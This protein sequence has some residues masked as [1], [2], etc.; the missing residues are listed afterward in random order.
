[1]TYPSPPWRLTGFGFQTIH[2]LDIDRVSALIPS[3]LD[4]VSVLPGKTLGTVYVAAYGEGSALIYNE[5][6][7]VNA[8]VRHGSKIGPWI[9]H[10]YVDHPDS[11]AGGRELWGLPKELAQFDWNLESPR[12]SVCVRQDAEVLCKLTSQ[13]QAPGLPLPLSSSV[14]SVLNSALMTFEAQA[15]VKVH[16]SGIDLQIPATSPFA[17][18]E[19]GQPVLSLYL[20][21][22]QATIKAPV[23][24]E[25]KSNVNV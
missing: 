7:V 9:S 3:Q 15:Q 21:P 6:I 4:I 12:S 18:V 24:V 1:M 11:V 23:P 25:E 19:P 14:F 20:N 10:I 16:L 22:L 8:L 2:L 17:W 5:L 13:W